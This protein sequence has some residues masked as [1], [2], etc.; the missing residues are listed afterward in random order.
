MTIEKR[1]VKS[2]ARFSTH[3]RACVTNAPLL[4]KTSNYCRKNMRLAK[5]DA[6]NAALVIQR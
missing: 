6:S 3:A 5:F 1:M 4:A 2:I